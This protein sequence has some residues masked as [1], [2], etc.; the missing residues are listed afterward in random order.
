[1]GLLSWI[2]VGFMAGWLAGIVTGTGGRRGCLG[3]IVLGVIGAIVGGWLMN[4]FGKMG[5]TG[6][7][8]WSIGVALLGAVVV[9]WI[10]NKLFGK[11]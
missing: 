10:R 5:P 7:N 9:L 3:N 6:F 4:F 1:M 2:I 8:M 11:S